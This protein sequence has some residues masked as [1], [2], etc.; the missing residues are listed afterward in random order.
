MRYKYYNTSFSITEYEIS[1]GIKKC[2][3]SAMFFLKMVYWI[4]IDSKILKKKK[5]VVKPSSWKVIQ[6]F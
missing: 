5:R 1:V 4:H 2:Y 3:I 6:L